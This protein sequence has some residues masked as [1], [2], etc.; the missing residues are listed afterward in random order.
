[1]REVEAFGAQRQRFA[2]LFHHEELKL[3]FAGQVFQAF[4]MM[5]VDFIGF[6]VAE[7]TH[8][9]LETSR[10]GIRAFV[11]LILRQHIHFSQQGG[12][13][14]PKTAMIQLAPLCTGP[15]IIVNA[16][17]LVPG[18]LRLDLLEG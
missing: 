13:V 11:P 17:N 8:A 18:I 1:M 12:I 9:R 2:A 16:E 6:S 5:H 4:H 15:V 3:R 7:F 14:F 10:E